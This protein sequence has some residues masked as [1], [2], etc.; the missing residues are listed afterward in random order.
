MNN[1]EV[2]TIIREYLPNIIHLSLG[3]MSDKGPWVCEVHFSYDDDLNLYFRSVPGT[4]HCQEISADPRVAG[5]IV[6]QHEQG[7]KPRGVYFEGTAQ[8]LDEGEEFQ[9]AF[10]C[11]SNRFGNGDQVLA[12]ARFEAG[13]HFYK[14][15]VNQFSVF[16]VRETGLKGKST[17]DWNK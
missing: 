9:K 16:N 17:M 10:E 8:R 15:T 6:Q 5:T 2:E 1:S 7:Q 12:D 11:V 14:I 4:R 3:T 13:P